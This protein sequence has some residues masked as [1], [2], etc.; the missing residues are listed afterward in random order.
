MN[1]GPAT[2]EDEK[3]LP[4]E[5]KGFNWAAFLWGGIWAVPYRVWIGL[6]AFVP[7]FGLIMNLVLGFRGSEW[8]FRKGSIP[9][10]AGFKSTQ[11]IWVIIWA[12]ASIFMIPAAIGMMSALTVFGVRK[13]VTQSKRA[14]AKLAL[15]QMTKGIAACAARGQLPESSA[16]IPAELSAVAGTKY[17]AA[18]GEWPSQ[19][20]FACAG[21]AMTTPQYYR[22]RWVRATATSGHFEAEADLNGDGVVDNALQQGVHCSADGCEVELLRGDSSSP[23]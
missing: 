21:F 16:W 6:L 18:P 11:R 22:Y 8:A 10:V 7:L 15:A 12:A 3:E 5:L 23:P 2:S 9:N 14:E 1:T 13:Y 19:A 20:A 17:Q 4:A